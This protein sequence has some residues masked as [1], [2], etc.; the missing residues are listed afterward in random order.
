MFLGPENQR[1]EHQLLELKAEIERLQAVL[2]CMELSRSWRITRPLRTFAA[3]IRVR[4]LE[5][6][7]RRLLRK[8]YL[9]ELSPIDFHAKLAIDTKH[10]VPKV[11]GIVHLFY[12]DLAVEIFDTLLKCDSLHSV[13]ITTPSVNDDA[14]KL[15]VERLK[16]SRPNLLVEIVWVENLGRDVLPFLQSADHPFIRECDVILKLHTKKSPHLSTRQGAIWRQQ[17]LRQLCPDRTIINYI[18]T[19]LATSPD[20]LIACPADFLAGRESWGANRRR[21]RQLLTNIGLPSRM[22]LIFPAGSMFWCRR[23]LLEKA[24]PLANYFVS[25]PGDN[26]KFDGTDAHAVERLF[27]LVALAHNRKVWAYTLSEDAGHGNP[28][29]AST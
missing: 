21:A 19:S 28:P 13:L 24:S 5:R 10:H 3:T 8:K 23:E 17:L 25:F 16:K 26:F 7:W 20:Y 18:V 14:L 12:T 4:Q 9:V 29:W 27:G 15:G 6:W 11:C 1:V 2:R 22:P